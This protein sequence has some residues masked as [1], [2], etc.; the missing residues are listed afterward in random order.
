M[1]M[2]NFLLKCAFFEEMGNVQQQYLW[3]E[4]GQNIPGTDPEK[5]GDLDNLI[6]FIDSGRG[7][8]Q[9]TQS[10]YQRNGKLDHEFI[11]MKKRR[12]KRFD[13]IRRMH[14]KLKDMKKEDGN[15]A[16]N[17]TPYYSSQYGYTGLEG[18]F[19]FPLAYYSGA[20][21][22]EPGAITNNPYNTIYQA[23]SLFA[24]LTK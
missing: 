20:L 5:S 22:N 14:K 2:S 6:R 15:I 19:E 1:T 24:N 4:L 9:D 13:R 18:T 3:N 21:T 8:Y 17:P 11:D 12:Q 16:F 7:Q 10:N 23:A